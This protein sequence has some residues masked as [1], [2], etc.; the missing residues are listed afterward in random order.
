[1][2]DLLFFNSL[3][4]ENFTTTMSDVVTDVK[5][6]SDSK[7]IN[8][9]KK[10]KQTYIDNTSVDL[11][12]LLQGEDFIGDNYEICEINIVGNDGIIKAV[13]GD[14]YAVQHRWF[15]PIFLY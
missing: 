11:S 8:V 6:K 12:T 5:L 14:Y 4:E 9:A 2:S 15:L 3:V 10:V 13:N 7:I 1:M